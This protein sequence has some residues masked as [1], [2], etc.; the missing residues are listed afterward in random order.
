MDP[1]IR[2]HTA[3]ENL[4]SRFDQH[5]LWSQVESRLR[6]ESIMSETSDY[7][8]FIANRADH[9]RAVIEELRPGPDQVGVLV[10]HGEEL[11]ALEVAASPSLWRRL[12]PR[13]L[14]GLLVGA[15]R[16]STRDVCP[17]PGQWLARV[18]A[19]ARR[20]AGDNGHVAIETAS[21]V[22]SGLWHE[23]AIAHCATFGRAES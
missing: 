11:V 20:G 18:A 19:A 3:A 12:A 9:R 21:I 2:R 6:G 13:A 16:L 1:E 8:T 23:G 14:P 5:R 4:G 22:G 10:L 15:E 17:A 7:H